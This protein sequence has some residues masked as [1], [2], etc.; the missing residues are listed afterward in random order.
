MNR[1]IKKA[2]GYLLTILLFGWSVIFLSLQIFPALIGGNN[3]H[4]MWTFQKK[5]MKKKF[6]GRK[7]LIIG[8]S[9]A[10]AF[11]DP[12]FLKHHFINL[13]IGG[14]SPFEGF[15][16]LRNFLKQ[17][18]VDTI[19]ISYALSHYM[20]S[21]LLNMR[22]L[23]FHLPTADELD[24]LERLESKYG[25][26]IDNEKPDLM[27]LIRRIR[28]ENQDPLV[29][30]ETFI[31]NLLGLFK[32]DARERLNQE[33]TESD[34]HASFGVSDSSAEFGEESYMD[35]NSNFPINPLCLSYLD[36]IYQLSEINH[37]RMILAFTP[38][39]FKTYEYIKDSKFYAFYENFLDS[40]K[41][42]YD[43]VALFD[44]YKFLPNQFFGDPNHA[45][46]KGSRFYSLYIKKELESGL[47]Q[48]SSWR[49]FG[50]GQ[51][52]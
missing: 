52:D 9:R 25:I 22:T 47:G 37:I 21:E 20:G 1:F 6:I 29:Y 31:N 27:T 45:N 40:L 36:S 11:F 26:T 3:E 23:A 16:S 10:L 46:P 4:F 44:Q 12:K 18:Q 51:R 5:V 2:M 38:V 17:N 33:M 15:I 39:N 43:D 19:I 13:S 50:P 49:K 28:F 30:R 41:T 34:G 8:D 32:R 42:R 24:K 7:N 48:K 14:A 35:Q